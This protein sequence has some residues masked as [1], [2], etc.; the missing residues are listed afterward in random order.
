MKK[1]DFIVKNRAWISY[2]NEKVIFTTKRVSSGNKIF[3]LNSKLISGTFTED[4]KSNC[5]FYVHFDN[6]DSINTAI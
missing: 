5:T 3:K 4:Y 6:F 2:K 1:M